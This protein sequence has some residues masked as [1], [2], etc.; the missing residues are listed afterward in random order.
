MSTGKFR[1]ADSYQQYSVSKMYGYQKL[2]TNGTDIQTFPQFQALR[3]KN[4]HINI[5]TNNYWSAMV[6]R[7]KICQ[8]KRKINE[9]TRTIKK[10][11]N[12]NYLELHIL[13]CKRRNL[14]LRCPFNGQESTYVFNNYFFSVAQLLTFLFL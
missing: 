14:F 10:T 1:L 7:E 4:Y 9:M 13:Q 2:T 12:L 8:K 5:R 11:P 6:W 3:Q